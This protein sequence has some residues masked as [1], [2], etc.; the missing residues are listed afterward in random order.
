MKWTKLFPPIALILAGIITMSMR[1]V[2]GMNPEHVSI[3]ASMPDQYDNGQ[4]GSGETTY[5]IL[6]FSPLTYIIGALLIIA[7]GF[8]LYNELK[9]AK[10]AN[11]Q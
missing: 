9:E 6:H 5:T 2:S 8:M 1:V 11:N 4:W 10:H 3:A 7:G